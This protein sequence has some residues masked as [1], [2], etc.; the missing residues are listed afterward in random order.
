MTSEHQRQTNRVNAQASTG[1]KTARGKARAAK[2]AF[3]HGLSI[4]V[5]R[6][7]DLA[8]KIEVWAHRIA[9]EGADAVVLA[10]ARG[11]AEAQIDLQRVKACRLR[12]IERA[13]ADPDYVGAQAERRQLSASM[14]WLR[15]KDQGYLTGI[16]PWAEV[17]C[18]TLTLPLGPD[19]LATI[20]CDLVHELP[21]L[22]RYERR[23]RWRRKRAI[24]EFD[25]VRKQAA[26]ERRNAGR[27]AEREQ[28][29]P[30]ASSAALILH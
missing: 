22:D 17:I 30:C 6:D 4:T 19:K 16:T 25:R 2:N 13:L 26:R 23:A 11:I 9:G 27:R 10:A 12:L 1:P 3:R 18:Q 29:D 28:E 14:R 20:L 5:Y 15:L 8:P 21:A 24:R 7:P